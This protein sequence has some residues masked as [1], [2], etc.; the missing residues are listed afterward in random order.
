MPVPGSLREYGSPLMPNTETHLIAHVVPQDIARGAQ[1]YASLMTQGIDDG[2]RHEILTLFASETSEL[3]VD[4]A[5]GIPSGRMRYLGLDPRVV[6]ALRSRLNQVA[7]D[8]V[9]AHGGEA[10]KYVI[11]ALPRVESV[12][13]VRIGVST[14]KANVP[15]R[16]FFQSLLMRTPDQIVAVSD[17]VRCELLSRYRVPSNK[18]TVIPNSRDESVFAPDD[19]ATDEE[20]PTLIFVGHLIESKRPELFLEVV[21]RLRDHDLS[22]RA[23]IVG[24]GPLLKKVSELAAAA[25]VEALGRRNDIP[26]LMRAADVFVFTSLR[27][28]EGMPGVLIEAALSGLSIVSTDVPGASDVVE[29]GVSGFIVPVN[30]VRELE[31][32]VRLLIANPLLR[33]EMGRAARLRAEERFTL[34][35]TSRLWSQVF[36]RY[37]HY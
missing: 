18:V 10:L 4:H 26:D 16:R 13:Y 34:S 25:Q 11:F 28:G 36:D 19:S 37:L 2:H 30:D 27:E 5:L 12:I 1:R 31:E 8:V 35:A 14:A 21:T 22:F 6:I 33:A 32:R 15:P 9:V 7:P 29:D 23:Q 24:A 17:A 3:V 20:S